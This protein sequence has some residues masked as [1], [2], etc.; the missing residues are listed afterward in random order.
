MDF[1]YQ[2]QTWFLPI[3]DDRQLITV[4]QVLCWN[5]VAYFYLNNHN[6]PDV[7]ELL[8]PFCCF[9]QCFVFINVWWPGSKDKLMELFE[10]KRFPTSLVFQSGLASAKTCTR[11]QVDVQDKPL[12][13]E[14]HPQLKG[15]FPEST[16]LIISLPK[17]V[18]C[19]NCAE[20]ML[21]L[22]EQKSK[23]ASCLDLNW[24]AELCFYVNINL[25]SFQQVHQ[26]M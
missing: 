18:L 20:Y 10:T 8:Q 2:L 26:S 22:F 12:I 14:L 9:S 6:V 3:W 11:Q 5:T 19:N 23:I 13:K 7:H 4:C 1:A 16:L 15:K 25:S 17:M 21:L 24:Q